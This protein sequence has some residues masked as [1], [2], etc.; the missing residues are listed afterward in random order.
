MS[1][2]N[3]KVIQDD[4]IIVPGTAFLFSKT[5][6]GTTKVEVPTNYIDRKTT[7]ALRQRPKPR[8]LLPT[9]LTFVHRM[10]KSLQVYGCTPN[11]K[12][13]ASGSGGHVPSH[14]NYDQVSLNL[15]PNEQTRLDARLKAYNRLSEERSNLGETLGEFKATGNMA[16]KRI[17]Q[18]AEIALALKRG[19]FSHL[20]DMI[21]GN[22]PKGVKRLS[23][24]R[25]L[26]DGWLELEFGWKPL[27]Q[28]VFDS[29]SILQTKFETG[30]SRLSKGNGTKGGF[31]VNDSSDFASII[32]RIENN[33]PN[34]STKLYSEVS[35]A[36][37]AK[38]NALGIANPA[39]LAW[40]LL[41][42]SFVVD[43]FIP[44]G[45][46]LASWTS[47]LGYYVRAECN[48]EETLIGSR[49]ECGVPNSAYRTVRRTVVH[50]PS[51]PRMPVDFNFRANSLWHVVTAT[52]LLIKTFGR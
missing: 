19:N 6:S 11:P 40:D 18:V 17:R 32:R 5:C 3:L 44:V 25:R 13:N 16:A 26:A 33:G 48:V 43:W 7:E 31:G 41:P 29:L 39:A 37:I 12:T 52:A 1:I 9:P 28:D 10:E 47:S 14:N 15:L 45:P 36:N 51:P 50:H 42:F 23:A 46:A 38:L 27:V 4:L 30:T 34:A 49:C 8:V 22:V 20:G 24:S 21:K 2:P 35:N